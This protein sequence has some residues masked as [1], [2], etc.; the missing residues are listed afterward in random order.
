MLHFDV[1]GTGSYEFDHLVLDMNGTLAADGVLL[2]GVQARLNQLREFLAIHVLTSDTFG[3]AQEIGV[4]L[5]LTIG[6]VNPI[7]GAVDKRRYVA[8]LGSARTA[9]IGNGKNDIGM[10]E[11]AAFSIAVIG[12]EGAHAGVLGA[13]DCVVTDIRDALDMLLNEKRFIAANRA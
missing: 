12:P 4:M 7:Q 13:A 10:L 5:N 2:P 3:K 8:G 9:A 11:E 6:I 1:P